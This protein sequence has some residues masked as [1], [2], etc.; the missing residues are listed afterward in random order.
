MKRRFLYIV[1]LCCCLSTVAQEQEEQKGQ[2]VKLT[3]SIQ[4]D[5]LVPMRDEAI[6]AQ[7]TEYFHTNTYC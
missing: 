4:S 7:K 3:G 6:G 1:M 2:G 5:M